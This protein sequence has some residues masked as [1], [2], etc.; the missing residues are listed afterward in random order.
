MADNKTQQLNAIVGEALKALVEI[1]V[2]PDQ[3]GA[4]AIS[5][6][7][8]AAALLGHGPSDNDVVD[9]EE[10]IHRSVVKA[11]RAANTVHEKA[12]S[13]SAKTRINVVV[14]GRRTSVT[15]QKRMVDA[16]AVAQGSPGKGKALI[17]DL[18]A[19]APDDVVNRSAW[20]EEALH[21]HLV[22]LQSKS[23]G[24]AH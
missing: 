22:L 12:S 7:P 13:D 18:A 11:M 24:M 16:A 15:I 8:R 21:S 23:Q 19:G 6:P 5:Y 2:A 10:L 14:Q 4:F 20:T 17:Q 9:L 3:V 1:G